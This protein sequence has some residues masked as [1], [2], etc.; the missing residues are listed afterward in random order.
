[1]TSI[2]EGDQKLVVDIIAAGPPNV[3]S[4]Q[5]VRAAS[6]PQNDGTGTASSSV[7]TAGGSVIDVTG[8]PKGYSNSF[9]SA[10]LKVA[11]GAELRGNEVELVAL[12]G[13]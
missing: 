2:G 6:K 7:S 8:D 11:P 3:Q 12:P 4:L 5:L 9:A 1:M 10:G 13:D